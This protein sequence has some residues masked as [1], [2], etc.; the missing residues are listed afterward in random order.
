MSSISGTADDV[1]PDV[2]DHL[3]TCS[4][5]HTSSRS[6][7]LVAAGQFLMLGEELRP[8]RRTSGLARGALDDPAGWLQIDRPNRY[9]QRSNHCVTQRSFDMHRI[10]QVLFVLDFRRD[11]D[12]FRS[13]VRI[14]QTERHGPTVVNRVVLADNLLDVL[15]IDVLAGDDDEVG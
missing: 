10:D 14:V 15:G 9:T 7:P 1:A 4:F 2:V 5:T 8:R 3:L 11:N 12:V 13:Q 6:L